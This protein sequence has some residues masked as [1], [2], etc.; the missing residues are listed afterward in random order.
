MLE[1]LAIDVFA[2]QS[3]LQSFILNYITFSPILTNF[4]PNGQFSVLFLTL[5]KGSLNPGN[6]VVVC[7]LL[8][9]ACSSFPS[10]NYRI[11]HPSAVPIR[12]CCSKPLLFVSRKQHTTF[13]RQLLT[14]NDATYNK[15]KNQ[16]RDQRP[17]SVTEMWVGLQ[18]CQCKTWYFLTRLFPYCN[19]FRNKTIFEFKW[20]ILPKV[21][22]YMSCFVKIR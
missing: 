16:L 1:M 10:A 9:L 4:N 18:N 12:K 6:H 21:E 19:I 2:A 15:R 13:S 17:L 8:L 11:A 22:S 20:V 7:V 3:Q 5:C 14:Q